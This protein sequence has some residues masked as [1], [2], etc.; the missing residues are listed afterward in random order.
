VD[1]ER[2][3]GSGCTNFVK[4]GQTTGENAPFYR[5]RDVAPG[6]TYTYRLR[7]VG[8]MG[9]SDYSATL[10]VATPPLNP[11]A[12]PSNLAAAMS[13]TNVSLSWHDNAAN[14][15]QF[16]VE[17]CQGA[18]C[19]TFGP[20]GA[21]GA[22]ENGW[23]DYGTAAGQSYT[24]RVRAWNSNGYSGYSNTAS[25]VVPDGPPSPPL[26]PG[27]LTAQAL[28]TGRVRLAWTNNGPQQ[29]LVKIERCRGLSCTNFAQIAAVAGTATTFTDSGLA[30]NTTY[31]YRVRAHN[32]AGDSPYSNTATVRTARR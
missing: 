5:D 9:A 19:G 13:G 26:A 8:F 21:T 20:V 14:E 15:T 18:G 7:A 10:E 16:F 25:I 23:T 30:R 17:R 22:N 11:P 31:R 32:G 2:C 12:A 1:V 28:D 29:D 3:T 6:V 24:Y 27:N 4:V